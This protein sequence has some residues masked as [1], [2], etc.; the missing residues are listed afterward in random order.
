MNARGVPNAAS[1][2]TVGLIVTVVA[3]IH[4]ILGFTIGYGVARFFGIDGGDAEFEMVIAAQMAKLAN[5]LFNAY[6]GSRVPT[7]RI[8]G[9]Q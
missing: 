4:N 7:A 5:H 3:I 2:A 8:P 6:I 9:Q 1:I